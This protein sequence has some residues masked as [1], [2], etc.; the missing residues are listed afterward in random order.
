MSKRDPEG[1]SD[2]QPI[3]TPR[4]RGQKR[5]GATAGTRPKGSGIPAS[6]TP[7]SGPGYGGPAKGARPAITAKTQPAPEAKSLGHAAAA[8]AREAAD[9][10]KLRAV[11]VWREIMDDPTAPPMARLTAADKI[12][13]RAEGAP[14]ERVVSV[15]VDPTDL[16][17]AQLAAIVAGKVPGASR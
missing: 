14:I 2:D 16:S 8:S 6:G 5:G 11:E 13:C 4:A 7:A 10:H 15:D 9:A 1:R 3:E 12:V 17:D